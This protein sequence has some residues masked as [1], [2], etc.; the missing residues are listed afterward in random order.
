MLSVRDMSE[1]VEMYLKIVYLL[2]TG[3]DGPARTGEIG[4]ELGVSPASVTGMLERL[5]EEGLVEHEKYQGARLSER[6]RAI[7]RDI[8]QKHCLLERFLVEQL[9][10]P[11]D[12]FHDQACKM[13]H[14]IYDDT[15][16]RMKRIV[17]LREE[18]PDCYDPKAL[19]CRF[20]VAP[21]ATA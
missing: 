17:R 7:A 20:L 6:G 10:V 4:Q 14:V 19:H 3:R 16:E 11:E 12:R 9:G 1:N 2:T 15:A 5:Q 8:L 18:C 13:E 21:T